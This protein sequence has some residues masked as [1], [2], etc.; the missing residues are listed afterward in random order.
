MPSTFVEQPVVAA[1]PPY[2][3]SADQPWNARRVAH[4]YR[5]LGFGAT[6]QQIDQGLQMTPAALVDQLL[7]TAAALPPLTPPAWAD[8]TAADYDA[9]GFQVTEE[10]RRELRHRWLSDMLNEGVRA[11]MALFWHD[12]FVTKIFIVGCNAYLWRYYELLHRRAFGNFR[13][14][15]LEM[16]KN[17]AMLVF[18]NGNLNVAGEPNENYAR[19]LMELF[20]LGESNGY[21][22]LDV[23]E[24]SR[25][26]TGWR[27]SFNDCTP[28]FFDPAKHDNGVK[29]IFGQTG[30]FGFDDAHNLIFSQRPVEASTYIAGKIYQHYLYRTPDPAAAA[31][32]AQTLRDHNWEIMPMLKQLFKSAHFFEEKFLG[33][34]M[35]SPLDLFINLLKMSGARYPEEVLPDWWD[36]TL[37]WT[38]NLGQE[39]FNPPNV[40]GW[41]EH[42]V[43]IN[44]STLT[45]RWNYGAIATQF[46][47]QN[48][49]LRENLR[50]IAKTR[51]NNS[52]NPEVITLALI[53][54]FTGQTLAPLQQEAAVAYFKAGVPEGYFTNG[55]WDLDFNQAPYQII[56]L[57]Q[58]LVK[59]P[60]FQL[61]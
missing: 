48:T 52:K 58:Y 51:S 39:I 18:L 25:A 30:N 45:A 29:T 38:R 60:E 56:N 9:A 42:R 14:F 11:K 12:H 35:K 2:T 10:H 61:T 21:T 34:K 55:I 27:A 6:L 40:A 3:P 1:L 28:A 5:R 59:I 49:Q 20:T 47:S 19:E 41:P 44:E 4:L 26:L 33:T 8:W 46:L 37:F 43:W 22:Q 17:P 32:M 50:Q 16:G 23:V 57:L 31:A 36:D 15:V 24:M 53:D 13:E 54:F 7:D